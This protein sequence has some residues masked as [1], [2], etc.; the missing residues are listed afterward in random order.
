MATLSHQGRTL[1]LHLAM[2][3]IPAGLAFMTG[4][5]EYMQLGTWRYPRGKVLAAHNHNPVPR[6]AERTQEML[7]V[8]KGRV[9]ATIYGEDDQPVGELTVAAGEVLL[10]LAGGHGYEILEDDTV[11]IE[12]KNGPYPGA[13]ADRRRL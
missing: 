9:K 12:A 8:L 3:D 5:D 2:D 11:V 13:E 1:A 10:L 4:D 6:R 7:V